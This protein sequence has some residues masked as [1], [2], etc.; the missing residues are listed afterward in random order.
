MWD[1][2]GPGTN[3]VSPALVDRFLNTEPAGK[4]K[5]DIFKH[6]SFVLSK[7]WRQEVQSQDIN[8]AIISLKALAGFF[9]ASS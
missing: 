2:P 4:P 5:L 6:E 3:P 8:R 1:L 7:F 9:P